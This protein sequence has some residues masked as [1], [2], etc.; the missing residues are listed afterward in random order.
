MYM[1]IHVYIYNY[2]S[3]ADNENGSFVNVI[4]KLDVFVPC[5]FFGWWVKVSHSLDFWLLV[6][7]V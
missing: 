7:C 6:P 4:D 3:S 1:Y 2:I 5:H